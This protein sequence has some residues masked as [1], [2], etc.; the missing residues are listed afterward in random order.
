MNSLATT[1]LSQPAPL[2][3]VEPAQAS[4]PSAKAKQ[5]AERFIASLSMLESPPIWT[6]PDAPELLRQEDRERLIE[7]LDPDT[8]EKLQNETPEGTGFY[9]VGKGSHNRVWGHPNYPNLVF[10]LMDREKTDKQVH[11]AKKSQEVVREIKNCW[12]QIPRTTSIDAKTTTIYVEERLPLSLGFQ[13]HQEFW[14]RILTYYQSPAC[15]DLF[16]IN[17]HQLIGQI[18]LL[19]E[20]V[21]FWDVGYHNLPEVRTDGTGV[22]GT[23]FENID[24][25]LK[26]V[27]EGLQRLAYLVPVAPLRDSIIKRHEQEVPSLLARE[28]KN[29]ADGV[30]YVAEKTFQNFHSLLELKNEKL[31][32]LQSAIKV[33]D[34]R[35]YVAGEE[36]ISCCADLSSLDAQEKALAQ[37]LLAS[38]QKDHSANKQRNV[39]LSDKRY[40]Y[41]QPGSCGR[42]YNKYYTR[43]RFLKVLN[44]LKE[45]NIVISWSDDYKFRALTDQE[46]KLVYYTIRY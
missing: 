43:D 35:G 5:V 15:S 16:K 31:E 34:E 20:R 28:M 1:S 8:I 27:A 46:L 9:L 12:I 6:P 3:A 45:Q 30:K 11:V 19:I 7:I 14:A 25:D 18:Q 41:L 37:A 42:G 2:L 38:I 10:K 33:Y 26:N 21:G 17:L 39:C 29:H 24:L 13:E 40:V 32:A 44:L 23:D 22:C 36:E 4:T